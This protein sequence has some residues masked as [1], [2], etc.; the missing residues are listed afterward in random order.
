[1]FKAM[2]NTQD[3]GVSVQLIHSGYSQP[4]LLTCDESMQ[5][6]SANGMLRR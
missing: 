2:K 5:V 3:K 4:V 1:M 6:Y